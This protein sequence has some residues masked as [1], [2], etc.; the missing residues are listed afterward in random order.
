[1]LVLGSGCLLRF[2]AGAELPDEGAEFSGDADFD[3]VVMELSFA[4][5]VEAV[6]ESHLGFPGEV[7][8]PLGGAF[9]TGGEL[10]AD[11]GRDAVVGGLFDEDPAGVGIAA[12]GNATA[13]L[14]GP[15]GV[16]GGNEPEEGHEFLGMFE[17]AEGPDF[18]HGD[19]GGDEFEAFESHE[20]LDEWFAL[21]VL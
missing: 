4:Q 21:P 11:V 12:F 5:H 2:D 7:F 15:A 3:L 14:P 1:M 20:G 19:H 18:G 16:L 17:A 10:G 8:D 6:A 13:L 9:L